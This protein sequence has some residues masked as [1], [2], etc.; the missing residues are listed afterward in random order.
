MWCHVRVHIFYQPISNELTKS[1]GIKIDR[2]HVKSRC[3]CQEPLVGW[4]IFVAALYMIESSKTDYMLHDI[5]SKD[6]SWM[7]AFVI[8]NQKKK[9]ENVN[10]LFDSFDAMSMNQFLS[11]TYSRFV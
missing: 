8:L 7:S 3:T 2:V 5:S 10:K 1:L 11:G 9:D 6:M 4:S